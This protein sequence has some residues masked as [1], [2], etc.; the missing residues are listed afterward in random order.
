MV[1]KWPI[2][3][4]IDQG[5]IPRLCLWLTPNFLRQPERIWNAKGNKSK[6]AEKKG[7]KIGKKK[8]RNGQTQNQNKKTKKKSTILAYA[9]A[10]NYNTVHCKFVSNLREIYIF[11]LKKKLFQ[12]N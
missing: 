1:V 8:I 12:Q 9:H 4:W 10:P 5:P 7:K 3:P 2:I 11:G 6:R